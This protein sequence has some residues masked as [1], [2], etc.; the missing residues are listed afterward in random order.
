MTALA[1]GHLRGGKTGK[2]NRNFKSENASQRHRMVA[3]LV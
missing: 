1:Q 3:Q 2:L